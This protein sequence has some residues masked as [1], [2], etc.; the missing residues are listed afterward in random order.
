[1]TNRWASSWARRLRRYADL[2]DTP[3]A[4]YA[5]RRRIPL[6]L[7]QFL[8]RIGLYADIRTVLDVGANRGQFARWCA[9]LFPHAVI[10]AFEPLSG[11]QAALQAA[12]ASEPRIRVHPTALGD[13]AGRAEMFENDY[14]PSSSFLPMLDRHREISPKTAH[15]RRIEVQVATLDEIAQQSS[16]EPPIFM[17]LDVQGFELAVLRGAQ[18]TLADTTVVMMEILVEPLYEG[19][20]GFSEIVGFMDAS[21]FR[22]LEFVEER[23]HPPCMTLSYADAA[24]LRKGSERRPPPQGDSP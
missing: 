8:R 7:Y 5:R 19:Q 9:A 23:R 12:A 18:R 1:M 13:H 17:K 22:F 4:W 6:P 3:G 2:L 10:H 24:F 11:C 21:G 14:D 16:F 20:A 15:A